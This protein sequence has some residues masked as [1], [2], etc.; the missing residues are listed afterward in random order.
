MN[1]FRR[2]RHGGDAPA[3]PPQA[4]VVVMD[5]AVRRRG[6][7]LRVRI[8]SPI[9]I[10]L[11]LGTGYALLDHVIPSFRRALGEP[12]PAGGASAQP[13]WVGAVW[14]LSDSVAG[15]RREA[16]V[17][18]AAAGAVSILLAIAS[19]WTAYLLYLL[20]M[21]LVLADALV[22]IGALAALW[23]SA[24]GDIGAM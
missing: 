19:R 5:R 14:S 10:V 4:A 21:L 23:G 6:R 2:R 8:L 18:I 20:A 11:A 1:W 24:M 9:L 13:R 3:A 22:F 15:H 12:G 7:A 17:L 16:V